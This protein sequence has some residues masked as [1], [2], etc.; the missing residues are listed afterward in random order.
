ML[1]TK[2]DCIMGSTWDGFLQRIR[3]HG[4]EISVCLC[5][6]F[7]L[8]SC[9]LLPNGMHTTSKLFKIEITKII[10]LFGAYVRTETQ[11]AQKKTKSTQAERE[12]QWQ[13][14]DHHAV[15]ILFVVFGWKTTFFWQVSLMRALRV[16]FYSFMAFS[17]IMRRLFR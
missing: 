6:D 11:H 17:M 14:Y 15:I 12:T 8:E 1:N 13:F 2:R 4:T 7:W 10:Q 9:I 5:V 3:Q 16:V